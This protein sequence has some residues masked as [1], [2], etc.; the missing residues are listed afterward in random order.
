MKRILLER[1]TTLRG[2]VFGL[3][4]MLTFSSSIVVYGQEPFSYKSL[5]VEIFTDGVV[6]V[7]FSLDVDATYTSISIPLFC[8]PLS[9]IIVLNHLNEPLDYELTARVLK[10]YTLGTH[11][12]RIIYETKDLT[13]E[14]GGGVW[15]FHM[16]SPINVTIVLP[17]DANI[18]PNKPPIS[19]ETVKEK[20]MLMMPPG[21]LELVYTIM[22]TPPV[23]ILLEI[24]GVPAGALAYN[25][26]NMIPT[27]FFKSIPADTPTVFMFKNFLLMVNSSRRLDL[28]LNVGSSVIMKYLKLNLKSSESLVLDINV[29]VSPPPDIVPPAGDINFYVNITTVPIEATLG[30]HINETALEAEIEEDIDISRLTWMYWDGSKWVPVPSQFDVDGYLVANTTHLSTWSVAEII[31]LQVDAQISPEIVTQ[32][33]TVTISAT[34]TDNVRNPVA[35]ATVKV[36]IGDKT[37]ILSDTGDGN[38]N[39]IFKTTDL[40]EGSYNIVVSAQKIGYESAQTSLKLT[41]KAAIPW[42]LYG[43]IIGVAVILIVVAALYKLKKE[44]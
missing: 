42:M 9:D 4:V 43:G 21:S 36:A 15:A 41:V 26:S 18:I 30:I 10:V 22:V 32:G 5:K 3:I 19:V 24:P 1:T 11:R 35:G 28:S 20:T 16:N 44:S 23:P 14:I 33:D 8:R 39:E 34:V 29:D 7:D 27:K 31:P 37:I 38:Y 17:K 6:S 13:S 40:T 25:Y 12:I 2:L